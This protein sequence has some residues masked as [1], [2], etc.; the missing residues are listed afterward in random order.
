[1]L[2]IVEEYG[3]KWAMSDRK[4]TQQITNHVDYS[5]HVLHTLGRKRICAPLYLKQVQWNLSVT[6]TSIIN[7]L[8]VIYSV[9]CINED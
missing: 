8:S 3:W 5:W 9:M 1:M 7:L 2:Q 6:T 4:R